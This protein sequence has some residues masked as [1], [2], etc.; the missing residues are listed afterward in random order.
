MGFQAVPREKG[1]LVAFEYQQSADELK[2]IQ[3]LNGKVV[4]GN[5][6]K[7]VMKTDKGWSR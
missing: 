4:Q 1:M 6:L 5:S 7:I 2:A 3:S